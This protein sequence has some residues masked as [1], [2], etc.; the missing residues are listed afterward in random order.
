MPARTRISRPALLTF[1]AGGAIVAA[2]A[3]LALTNAPPRLVRV[4]VP[5]VK[6]INGSGAAFIGAELGDAT[7][8]QGDETLPRGVSGVRV[9]IWAFLGAAIAVHVYHGA[10]LVTQGAHNG[11][12]T[13]DS[14]TVPVTP[15]ARTVTGARLCLTIGPNSEPLGLLGP[16]T[17][18]LEVA[19][20]YLPEGHGRPLR[21]RGRVAVEYIAP[22][23]GTWWSRVIEVARRL[24]LGRAFA[25]TWIALL[26][27]ALM[28]AAATLAVRLTLRELR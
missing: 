4:G 8:C 17:P 7:V 21:L 26:I 12:W 18:G 11:A 19:R 23:A 5:G 6:A 15:L 10:Q 24:G 9:S 22:G 27:D 13:S 14:V 3:A 28:A 25:G 2:A 20:I 1:A 16:Q